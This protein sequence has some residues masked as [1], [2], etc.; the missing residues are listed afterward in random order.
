MTAEPRYYANISELQEATDSK[1]ANLLLTAGWELLSLKE[2]SKA[3]NIPGGVTQ[4]ME[5]V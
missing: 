3:F 4:Q 5:V 2:R 1:G